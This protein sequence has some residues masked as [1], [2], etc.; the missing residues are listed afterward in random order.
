MCVVFSRRLSLPGKRPWLRPALSLLHI[1]A[2]APIKSELLPRPP[3]ASFPPPP[4]PSLS[5]H[6][7]LSRGGT[8]TV[9]PTSGCIVFLCCTGNSYNNHISM[10]NDKIT[11]SSP[12]CSFRSELSSQSDCCLLFKQQYF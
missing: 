8:K 4:P 2:S 5:T 7:L 6:S 11:H 9:F 1:V 10:M 3:P 12:G